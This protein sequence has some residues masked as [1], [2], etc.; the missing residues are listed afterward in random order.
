M[1]ISRL[2][3][4]MLLLGTLRRSLAEQSPG[5]V[6]A[7]P[8]KS[9]AGTTLFL[10][11]ST[12]EGFSADGKYAYLGKWVKQG[13]EDSCIGSYAVIVDLGSG[14]AKNYVPPDSD[15][16]P[17]AI[18]QPSQWWAEGGDCDGRRKELK[19]RPTREYA[20]FAANHPRVS[21]ADKR[22]APDGQTQAEARI[23]GKRAGGKWKG[24]AY[25]FG[26]GESRE[27]RYQAVLELSL[28]RGGTQ[29]AKTRSELE[30][31]TIYHVW[32]NAQPCWS[33]DSQT[34]AWELT[35][36]SDWKRDPEHTE[37][38]LLR[39]ARPGK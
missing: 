6:R 8:E 19:L 13:D 12:F 24:N 31:S 37:L 7:R 14:A 21:C 29:V 15:G 36:K 38:V 10:G 39:T 20:A 17:S 1:T 32:G 3:L 5:N 2:V 26:T 25:S 30:S 27:E 11:G 9:A 35:I 22:V 23:L 28:S 33:A 4:V 18:G 34:I 16:Y